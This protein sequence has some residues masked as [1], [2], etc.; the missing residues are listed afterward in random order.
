MSAQEIITLQFGN[1][2]N[3]VGTHYWNFHYKRML[4]K[5]KNDQN[6]DYVNKLFRESFTNPS[7]SQFL[8]RTICFDIKTKLQSL[9]QDGTF[10]KTWESMD[11]GEEENSNVVD[12]VNC[13]LH[14]EPPI[15][16]NEFIKEAIEDGNLQ[17][18]SSDSYDLDEKVTTWS[19]FMTYELHDH[20]VQLL[21]DTYKDGE[22]FCYFGAGSEEYKCLRDDFEDNLHFWVE[23]CDYMEGFQVFLF[24]VFLFDQFF[25]T[26]NTYLLNKRNFSV[27]VFG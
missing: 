14:V 3:H 13:A 17:K 11:V 27:H 20:S 25:L 24:R 21:H 10:S 19:D 23:E 15:E 1:Y 2:S 6:N 16:R 12:G 7:R 5:Q 22:D 8:P 9:K 4:E 26:I 18:S